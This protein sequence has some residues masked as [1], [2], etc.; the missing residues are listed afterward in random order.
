MP[1][2]LSKRLVAH[3]VA[4]ALLAALCGSA[5][6]D[7]TTAET[8]AVPPELTQRRAQLASSLRKLLEPLNRSYI[9]ALRKAERELA[10]AGD[11]EAAIAARNERQAIAKILIES[12]VDG[13]NEPATDS[14]LPDAPATELT[15]SFTLKANATKASEGVTVI[16]KGATV[17][18]AGDTLSWKI[19]KQISGGFDVSITY[20]STGTASFWIRE[21]FFRLKGEVAAGRSVTAKLGT[22]KITTAAKTIT[23][24]AID[25][26]A[27]GIFIEALIFTESPD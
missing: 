5:N 8:R 26:P 14:A 12:K 20:S 16:A 1:H 21:S 2:P 18:A 24:D 23:L 25:I 3:L 6:A 27:E 9:S 17:N 22:L 19:P 10:I 4:A 11:Y 13:L 7:T 15:G